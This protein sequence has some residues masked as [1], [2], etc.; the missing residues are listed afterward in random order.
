[1]KHTPA[2][3]LL[4]CCSAIGNAYAA[5]DWLIIPATTPNITFSIDKN[6]LE[7]NGNLVKFREKIT[8]AKPEIRDE[9]SGYLI[10]EKK[11]HRVMN[12]AE[13]TQGLIHGATYGEHGRFITSISVD[14]TKVA[15]SEIPPNT[16]AGSELALV[17][18]SVPSATGQDNKQPSSRMP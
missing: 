15:M 8:Y 14:E 9:V 5:E 7:R 18:G 2:Y 3:L 11:T 4:L 10:T 1:M 17:C 13:Q 16:I 6:S 12:C